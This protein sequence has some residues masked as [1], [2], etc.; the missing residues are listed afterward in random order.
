LQT[1]APTWIFHAIRDSKFSVTT[2]FRTIHRLQEQVLKGEVLELYWLS[3]DLRIHKFKFLARSLD[4]LRYSFWTH[5]NPINARRRRYRSVCLDCDLKSSLLDCGN[6]RRIKLKQRFAAGDYDQLSRSHPCP[7][8]GNRGSEHISALKLPTAQAIHSDKVR[9]A[10][11][12]NGT[13]TIGFATRPQIAT[14]EPAKDRY[15]PGL[16]SFAL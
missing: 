3:V 12:A 10:E 11:P 1:Y 15:P 4:Q 5:A 2:P 16:G 7:S 9:I 14:S 13:P 8:A 6:Q